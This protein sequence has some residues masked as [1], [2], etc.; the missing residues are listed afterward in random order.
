MDVVAFGAAPSGG[1]TV[2]LGAALGSLAVGLYPY[3]VFLLLARAYYA[4]GDSRTPALVAVGSAVLGV[5]VMFAVGDSGS[6]TRV[7]IALGIGHTIAYVVGAIVL[8]VGL[9]R[10]TGAQL[11]PAV[12][13]RAALVSIPLA[14]GAWW[15]DDLVDPSSRIAQ[16]FLLAGLVLAG[17][18][19]YAA[20]FVRSRRLRPGGPGAEASAPE[21]AD[22]IRER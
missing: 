18:A 12:L 3:S 15:I 16:F 9:R 20:V 14:G 19:I 2:L 22:M 1:G 5:G 11:V 7:V 21:P 6:D 10:R 8:G 4:L 13:G 17:A